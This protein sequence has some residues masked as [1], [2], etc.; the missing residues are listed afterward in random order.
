MCLHV[1]RVCALVHIPHLFPV[2][3]TILGKVVASERKKNRHLGAL[4]H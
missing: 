4:R 2:K 3:F 1:S